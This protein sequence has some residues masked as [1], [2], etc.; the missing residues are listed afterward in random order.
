[1]KCSECINSRK[2]VSENG[3]HYICCLSSRKSKQCLLNYNK[4][5]N[6][7]KNSELE[8]NYLDLGTT[9]GIV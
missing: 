2:I 5:Y 9:Q 4:F 8:S 1:M 3:E 6:K 7:Y